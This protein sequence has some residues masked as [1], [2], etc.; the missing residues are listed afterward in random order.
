MP[1]KFETK[2]SPEIPAKI[3][4]KK[5]TAEKSFK[6]QKKQREEIDF[7]FWEIEELEE[8]LK[9]I[10]TK[11]KEKIDHGDYGLIIGDDA[12]GRIPTIIF[13]RF[14]KKICEIKNLPKPGIIF[15]PGHP[16]LEKAKRFLEKA[17]GLEEYVRKFGGTT[18]KRILIITEVVASGASLVGLTNFLRKKGIDL[19]I[20]TLGINPEFGGSIYHLN[21]MTPYIISG[22]YIRGRAEYQTGVPRISGQINIS[23]VEKKRN[24][25]IKSRRAVVDEWGDDIRSDVSQARADA[26]QMADELVEWYGNIDTN[27]QP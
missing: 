20:A 5:A 16:N 2:I 11:I 19:D 22:E 7:K 3:Q 27:Q 13:S 18:K 17:N 15:V 21:K 25:D 4:E 8:P 1:E 24:Y 12:S 26:K 10:I 9:K 6:N 23:G 14:I